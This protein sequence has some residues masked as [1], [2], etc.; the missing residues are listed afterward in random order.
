MS[1]LS[2][3]LVVCSVMFALAATVLA[4]I[5]ILP[6]KRRNTLP[7]IFR[8]LHDLFNF[9]FLIIEK[10]LQAAYIFAT[11]YAIIYGFIYIFA[12]F[13]TSYLFGT[14]W[15]GWMGF[16]YMIFGPIFI[17]VAYEGV[18]LI[19]LLVKNVIQINNKLKNQNE[20]TAASMF[21]LPQIPKRKPAPAAPVQPAPA[22]PYQPAPAAPVQPAPAAPVQPAPAAPM[23]PAFCTKCGMM[24]DANGKCPNCGQ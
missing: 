1:V 11:A 2:V 22:A 6:E 19:I 16:L 13:E 20:E 15:N 21:D 14:T 24:L 9:K 23:Q 8:V 7:G 4:F 3:V 18:L 17:R 10:I 12:G 5:F